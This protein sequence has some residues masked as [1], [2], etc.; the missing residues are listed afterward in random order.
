MVCPFYLNLIS[1]FAYA[2]KETEWKC[3]RERENVE[4]AERVGEIQRNGK[5][6]KMNFLLNCSE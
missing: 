5:C 2:L 4:S 1:C 6:K 3:E